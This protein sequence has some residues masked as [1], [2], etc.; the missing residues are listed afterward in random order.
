MAKIL[1]IILTCALFV[2]AIAPAEAAGPLVLR[3]ASS[4]PEASTGP[5][6]SVGKLCELINKLSNGELK[7]LPFYQSLGIENQLAAAVRAGSIDICTGASPN[8]ATFTDAFL[9]FDLPF[10]FKNDK[11]TIDALENHPV[12]K[13]A[14]AK[15]EKDMGVK[16]LLIASHTYD[17]RISGTDIYSRKKQV[18][19]PD[20]LKGMKFRTSGTPVENI[21]MKAYGANPSPLAYAQVYTALQ[22]GVIEAMAAPVT[23]SAAIKLYEVCPYYTAFCLRINVI[24]IYMNQKKFDSLTP[25]QQ[26]AILDA[27]EQVKPL[28]GKYARDL[29]NAAGDEFEKNGVKIYYPTKDEMAKWLAVREDVWKQVANEFK[30]KVDLDIANQLYQPR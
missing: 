2:F 11:G 19:V 28:A 20:D 27:A 5:A 6:L 24:P 7:A 21:L 10:L 3:A 13:K 18:R 1:G 12:G 23:P 29:A 25:F 30:G 22:Q 8:L 16:V 15:M 14:I 17:A 4:D 26:K 9:Q